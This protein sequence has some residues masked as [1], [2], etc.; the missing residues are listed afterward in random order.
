MNSTPT[1][2]TPR[3]S[4]GAAAEAQPA[5]DPL[6][7]ELWAWHRGLPTQ[8]RGGGAGDLLPALL[9]PLGDPASLRH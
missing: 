2:A 4:D 1:G 9:Q 3:Q 5:G 6:L 7:A 8:S